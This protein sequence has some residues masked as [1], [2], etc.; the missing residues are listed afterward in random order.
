MAADVICQSLFEP[1]SAPFDARRAM[2]L[3]T[4]GAGCADTYVPPYCTHGLR[5]AASCVLYVPEAQGSLHIHCAYHC[6]RTRLGRAV[7]TAYC[8]VHHRRRLHGHVR[9]AACSKNAVP[10]PNP[11][12]KSKPKPNPSPNPNLGS[13]TACRPCLLRL[14]PYWL[15]AAHHTLEERA[16][17]PVGG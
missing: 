8:V 6:T 2:A 9:S 7:R 16:Y 10:N 4:F 1:S 14:T 3:G 17:R 5:V 11:N 15:W 12:P 13:A